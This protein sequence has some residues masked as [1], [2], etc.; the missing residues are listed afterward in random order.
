M[1]RCTKDQKKWLISKPSLFSLPFRTKVAVSFRQEI[2]QNDGLFQG[3][4][5]MASHHFIKEKLQNGAR[6]KMRDTKINAFRNCSKSPKKSKLSNLQ[7][8]EF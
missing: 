2:L 8:P 6:L 1:Y 7:V 3:P 4:R 5:S